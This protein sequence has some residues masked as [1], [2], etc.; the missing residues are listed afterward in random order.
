MICRAPLAE[1]LFKHGNARSI[2]AFTNGQDII[3]GTKALPAGI[4]DA[5]AGG[6]KAPLRRADGRGDGAAAGEG[7]GG[8]TLG[9]ATPQ[10]RAGELNPHSPMKSPQDKTDLGELK[11]C[12]PV[13]ITPQ[14]EAEQRRFSEAFTAGVAKGVEKL[15]EAER[16]GVPL[17]K[18]VP[19]N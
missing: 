13:S 9:R 10:A 15:K 17:H 18:L 4:F 11:P 12:L 19:V 6:S 1:L 8:G 3:W 5:A 14:E 7:E 2:E 16:L